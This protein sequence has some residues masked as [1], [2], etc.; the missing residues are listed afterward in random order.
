[1]TTC[2]ACLTAGWHYVAALAGRSPTVQLE[3]AD[4]IIC[5]ER[6]RPSGVAAWLG[7]TL[8][9]YPGC[10]VAAAGI[11]DLESVVG[12]RGGQ[13]ITF[14]VGACAEVDDP[15]W[16]AL[17][18]GSFVHGW[19]AGGRP[20]AELESAQM[21]VTWSGA[22]AGWRLPVHGGAVSCSLG[23]VGDSISGSRASSRCRI[24]PSSGAPTSA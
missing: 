1:M 21:R 22:L 9:R 17:L 4:V 24:C 16:L 19:L 15:S 8:S 18:C 11:G 3:V 7:A 2:A 6:L 13:P 12:T 10:A 20:L 14:A 23:V 5:S